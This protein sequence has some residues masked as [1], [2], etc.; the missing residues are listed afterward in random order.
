MRIVVALGGNTLLKRGEPLTAEAQRAHVRAAAQALLPVATAHQLI[1]SHGSG[2]QNG[3][4]AW[5]GG[6]GQAAGAC[7]LP[8]LGAQ[9]EGMIGYLIEQ[10]LGSLLPFEVPFATLLTMAEVDA[11]DPGFENPTAFVGPACDKPEADRLAAAR[12]WVFKPEGARWRRVVPAPVPRRIVE[13][14]PI[15]WLLDHGAI[16]ICAGG[17]GI[18]TL[19]ARG[20]ERKLGVECVVDK[21]LCAELLARELGADLLVMLT[22]ANAVYL[23]WGKPTQRPIRRMSAEALAGMPFAAGSMGPKVEAACRFAAATGK[24]AA[25][26]ALP[27]LSRII[28][29]EAGTIVDPKGAYAA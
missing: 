15:R 18:P 2:P 6:A 16:V 10:E 1:I 29:G 26:G 4:L 7:P 19:C 27:D 23:D 28:A 12:G 11:D 22:D 17:G 21:D 20:R 9:T 14:G 24:R 5:E 3:I 25:I 8:L 13:I